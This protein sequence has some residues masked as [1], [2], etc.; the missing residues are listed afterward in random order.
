MR[1]RY[2][3]YKLRVQTV[4]DKSPVLN[5]AASAKEDLRKRAVELYHEPRWQGNGR[6]GLLLPP[7]T[8][9]LP[10]E[11]QGTCSLQHGCVLSEANVFEQFESHLVSLWPTR[12]I[13]HC[14]P[15][16][17]PTTTRRNGTTTAINAVLLKKCWSIAR[18]LFKGRLPEHA[19]AIM[20]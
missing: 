15:V 17:L 7:T 8:H 14:D 19:S 20:F 16:T 5:I 12:E 18:C 2:C 11:T 6:K 10:G 3:N 9:T 4:L 1:K 13:V